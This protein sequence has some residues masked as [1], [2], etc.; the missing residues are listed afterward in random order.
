MLLGGEAGRLVQSEAGPVICRGEMGEGTLGSPLIVM[1]GGGNGFEWSSE[2]WD[3]PFVKLIFLTESLRAPCI[4]LSFC[5]QDI[6]FPA[7]TRLLSPTL[8]IRVGC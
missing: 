1:A 2:W 8:N 3:V 7:A 6:L 5:A 4:V